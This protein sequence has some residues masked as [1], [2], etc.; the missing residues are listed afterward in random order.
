M[1]P[2]DAS[3]RV[4]RVDTSKTGPVKSLTLLGGPGTLCSLQGYNANAATRYI[5]LFD[6]VGLPDEGAVPAAV[7]VVPATSN[8]FLE[9]ILT[10]MRF[11]T[12]IQLVVS[13]SDTTKTLTSTNDCLVWGT[14]LGDT[15]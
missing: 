4:N 10:G 15:E 14:V 5:Q 13:T 11:Y 9:M 12:G 3:A 2:F 8:F 1:L 6:A 7:I